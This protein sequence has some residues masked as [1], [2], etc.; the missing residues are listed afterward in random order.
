M[1]MKQQRTLKL[2]YCYFILYYIFIYMAS[3]LCLK[4]FQMQ[5]I[6]KPKIL[7]QKIWIHLNFSLLSFGYRLKWISC[8][9]LNRISFKRTISYYKICWR[10][11]QCKFKANCLSLSLRVV[12]QIW[13]KYTNVNAA[14]NVKIGFPLSAIAHARSHAY[15]QFTAL[16]YWFVPCF[17][18]A[19]RL[20]QLTLSFLL[21]GNYKK[22]HKIIEGKKYFKCFPTF[23]L[24]TTRRG[25][26]SH[27]HKLWKG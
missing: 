9:S 27:I 23:H 3:S 7:A 24:I 21:F 19:F 12:F 6:H 13:I 16:E 15:F 22:N 18:R 26:K 2:G 10:T 5:M 4:R 14:P 8:H 17:V 11:C 1:L 25:K 20:S